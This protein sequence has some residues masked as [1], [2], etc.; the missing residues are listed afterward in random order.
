MNGTCVSP[1]IG[2]SGSGGGGGGGGGGA[3]VDSSAVCESGNATGDE[4][5]EDAGLA[6]P[7]SSGGEKNSSSSLGQSASSLFRR[8]EAVSPGRSGGGCRAQGIRK[9]QKCLSTSVSHYEASHAEAS[10]ASTSSGGG[11]ASSF[12]APFHTQRSVDIRGYSATTSSQAS[13]TSSPYIL[14]NTR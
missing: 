3:E 2:G 10:T 7:S 13:L 1:T 11:F 14:T 6:G 5:I 8:S 12:H 9:L 4:I